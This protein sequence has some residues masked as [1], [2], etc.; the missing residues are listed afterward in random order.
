[1]TFAFD[2]L[3]SARDVEAEFSVAD[4]E[5]V[6]ILG[7]NGAGKSTI[8]NV[9]AGLIGPDRGRVT[10]GGRVL[11]DVGSAG[12]RVVL[13]PWS[14][15]VSMLAQD[16]LLFPH[17]TVRDNVAF[18]PRSTG[19]SRAGAR[20]RA[21]EWLERVDAADL[22]RRRPS[23]LSGGQ[24]QRVAVARAL[25]TEPELLLLD[26]PLAA[27]DVSVA[28]AV[29]RML[30]DVLGDRTAIIVTHDVLDAYTLADRVVILE[31]GRIVDSGATRDVLDRPATPFAA[32]LAGLNL[33]LG[34]GDGAGGVVLADGRRVSGRAASAV[35]LGAPAGFSIRPGAV[36]VRS[37]RPHD[38]APGDTAMA[39][40]VTDLEPR[41]DVVRVRTPDLAADVSPRDVA[42][43]DLQPGSR[44]WF[45]VAAADGLV[46]PL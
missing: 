20:R 37:D 40:A 33:L 38:L 8:L 43:L 35:P 2:A 19:A 25:A 32:G 3:V 29:R 7:P 26:E 9:V 45:V 22:G 28:P 6:A 15:G 4:G 5:T 36:A 39:G 13:P 1:V 42:A 23:D 12:R 14:R 18:G 16:A 30:R 10:L 31:R 34:R 44:V 27:L 24:A 21:D 11:V 46:Y 41:G 17:L